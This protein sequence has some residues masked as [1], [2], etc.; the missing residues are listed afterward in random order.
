MNRDNSRFNNRLRPKSKLPLGIY[1][2]YTGEY[3][4]AIA[5][6]RHETTGEPMVVFQIMQEDFSIWFQS[7]T[8]FTRKVVSKGQI[9]KRYTHVNDF[10]S[11]DTP[12]DMDYSLVAHQSET[13]PAEPAPVSLT[14]PVMSQ[15]YSPAYGSST[16]TRSNSTSSI[17]LSNSTN[18]NHPPRSRGHR[19]RKYIRGGK[20]YR[21]GHP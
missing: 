7:P 2:H 13:S 18:S 20:I 15:T 3:V 17:T 1:R 12:F 8:E 16:M 11:R 21:T 4:N 9:M 19:P 5:I 6:A 14:D 10:P